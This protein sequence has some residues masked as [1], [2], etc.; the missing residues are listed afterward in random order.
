MTAISL[1][2]RQEDALKIRDITGWPFENYC[3]QVCGWQFPAY[4]SKPASGQ[5]W[6]QDGRTCLWYWRRN[7]IFSLFDGCCVKIYQFRGWI[8]SYFIGG[9]I[10]KFVS[11]ADPRVAFLFGDASARYF[12][13]IR[14]KD[15]YWRVILFQLSLLWHVCNAKSFKFGQVFPEELSTAVWDLYKMENWKT[16]ESFYREQ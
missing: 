10:S 2:N 7:F 5:N 13:V 6:K 16:A 11:K 8:Y 15:I 9:V 12:W 3:E 14:K 1:Q 4:D